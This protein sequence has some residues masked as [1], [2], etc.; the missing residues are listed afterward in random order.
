MVAANYF[1]VS[2]V[3]NMKMLPPSRIPRDSTNI[4]YFDPALIMGFGA[5]LFMWAVLCFTLGH[6]ELRTFCYTSV[7]SSILSP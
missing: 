2:A 7:T 3:N 4:A 6:P 5:L 1:F